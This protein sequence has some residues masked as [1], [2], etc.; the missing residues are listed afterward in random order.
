MT[1]SHNIK[2]LSSHDDSPKLCFDDKESNYSIR[3]GICDTDRQGSWSSN[4]GGS[5]N[6]ASLGGSNEGLSNNAKNGE[7]VITIHNK[8]RPSILNIY[9]APW[10]SLQYHFLRYSDVKQ[11]PEKKLTLSELSSEGLQRKNGWKVHHLV[12]H[13]EETDE[14][15]NQI[16]ERL[17]LFLQTF[18]K[19]YDT[20]LSNNINLLGLNC[21]NSSHF[22]S[23]IPLFDK[24]T[25]LI[26]GNL[27]RSKLF[28]EQIH[29]AK[30]LLIKLTN[31]HK[32]RVSRLTKKCVNKRTYINK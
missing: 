31:D 16:F 22:G 27:Q 4:S 18:E 2:L 26:R 29:E 30:S 5:G 7:V 6:G 11:K 28:Q 17:K 9:Q 32:E 12:T 13:I 23:T 14:E 8:P 10:K 19:N 15:E 25:D 20:S 24:L 1:T 21:F 3:E